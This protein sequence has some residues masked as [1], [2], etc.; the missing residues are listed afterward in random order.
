MPG[1]DA[2]KSYVDPITGHTT[3]YITTE[4][5]NGTTAG[6]AYRPVVEPVEK[7]KATW[8]NQL[9]GTD[10]ERAWDQVCVRVRVCALVCGT[11]R[12]LVRACEPPD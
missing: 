10:V 2:A 1:A 8:Y 9:I 6:P 5:A 3:R 11:L 4:S 7:V 12:A